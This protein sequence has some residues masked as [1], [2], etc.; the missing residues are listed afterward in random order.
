ML[1]VIIPAYNEENNIV[2]TV[3]IIRKELKTLKIKHEI[4]I[5]DDCSTD[6]TLK[7]AEKLH[8][9]DKRIRV[10]RHRVNKGPGSGIV[11][12]IRHSKGSIIIFLP[13]DLAMEIKEIRKYLDASKTADVVLGVRSDRSDYSLFRKIVS[14]LNIFMIKALFNMKEK[15]F[16]YIPLYRSRIFKNI[17]IQSTGVFVTAEIAI[18][19][20]YFG[21][22]INEVFIKYIPRTHGKASCGKISVIL[23]TIMEMLKFWF[24]WNFTPKP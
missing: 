19:A 16:N 7:I 11:T 15:Q 21:F 4:L 6:N 13:A 3:K 14:L 10:I 23:K 9:G 24:K 22:K 12:G 2:N 17:K 1:T 18:K 20:K 8:A 5:V